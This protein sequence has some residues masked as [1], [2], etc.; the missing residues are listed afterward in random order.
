MSETQTAPETA[1]AVKPTPRKKYTGN[2]KKAKAPAKKT[3]AK[4]VAPKKAAA[5]AAAPK[6]KVEPKVARTRA[7]DDAVITWLDKVN[8]FRAGSGAHERTELLRKASGKTV[9]KFIEAGG[10]RSTVGTC[11]KLG[12]IK[13]S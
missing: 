4:K 1:P 8:P 7:A 10:R 13:L 2:Y 5:K 9:A 12:L 6:A 3:A 11:K